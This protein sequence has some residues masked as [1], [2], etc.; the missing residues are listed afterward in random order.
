MLFL[1]P[2]QKSIDSLLWWSANSFALLPHFYTFLFIQLYCS[3]LSYLEHYCDHVSVVHFRVKQ[4]I[5]ILFSFSY[6]FF[7]VWQRQYS[8]HICTPYISQLP[9]QLG[10]VHVTRLSLWAKAAKGLCASFISLFSREETMQTMG[11]IS[12][13]T[14]KEDNL[15]SMGI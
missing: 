11:S 12:A 4:S 2:F 7:L 6:F 5:M 3:F 10:W 13:N 1:N 8:S 15:V 14:T 9:F